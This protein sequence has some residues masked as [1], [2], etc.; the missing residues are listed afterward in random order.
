MEMVCQMYR[1]FSPHDA[2]ARGTARNPHR[3]ATMSPTPTYPCSASL[4]ITLCFS[5]TKNPR[6]K[7]CAGGGLD[8]V[9]AG[10][11]PCD[12]SHADPVIAGQ[13][14]PEAPKR[15]V[16]A[17]ADDRRRLLRVAFPCG[18]ASA[19]I[20]LPPRAVAVCPYREQ[21]R[22]VL[23]RTA[24][25]RNPHR[26]M[27]VRDIETIMHS[28][29]R[30][31]VQPGRCVL[32]YRITHHQV[33]GR[34]ILRAPTRRTPCLHHIRTAPGRGAVAPQC[35]VGACQPHVRR[36]GDTCLQ[37][38]QVLANHTLRPVRA[39]SRYCIG[40]LHLLAARPRTSGMMLTKRRGAFSKN[41]RLHGSRGSPV[42]S[43]ARCSNFINH[44][45]TAAF[46][47]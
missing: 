46:L 17:L 20:D 29:R 33:S 21:D 11:R 12:I 38:R 3:P 28:H 15:R 43:R 4:T 14:A 34:G 39:D 40:H 27:R 24:Q 36:D 6:S 5:H 31:R 2:A 16:R 18:N 30:V 10:A 41:A 26:Y 25:Y 44:L 1:R 19:G 22:V 13:S 9:V 7:S 42:F 35:Q 37:H 47:G 8:G 45:A 23:P 32:Q